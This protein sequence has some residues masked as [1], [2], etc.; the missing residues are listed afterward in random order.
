MNQREKILLAGIGAIVVLWFGWGL[1]NSYQD[2][3]DRRVRELAELDES[4]FDAGVDARRARQS[5]RR[6]ESY[7]EQSLPS[8][9][10]VARSVYSAWLI[11]TIQKS[12]LELG[13]V[14][15]AAMREYEEAATSLTFTATATGKPEAVVKLLDA[16]YRLGVLH[17]LTNLQ[18][19][20]GN[21]EGDEWS[22]TFTS[23]A[24]V[25]SG[26]TRDAGLP[27]TPHEPARLAKPAVED[28]VESVV[29]RNLFA[30]Y[31]PPPPPKPAP[32]TVVK[33]TP[34][35]APSPPPFDDAEHAA[36]SAVVGYG[37][38]YEAW[39]TVRT[40]G[41]TLRVHD[42]DALEV[43]QFKGRVESV[44]Q[45][46]MTVVAED[47]AKFTVDLGEMIGAAQKASKDAA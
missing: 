2:G 28:Y 45:R 34:K 47:G 35:P 30:S 5:L 17:Q 43:G 42:G 21:E 27:E 23:V 40:T 32:T 26:A 15:F 19:R 12:G 16:Y 37:D 3:Y 46:A 44:G 14:K 4:L 1:F 10:D 6:L 31:T 41:I 7:Q 29:G 24:M 20:P 36:L 8:D 18:L 25:I 39:I 11:D 22:L 38:A 9:P 33:E 13:S